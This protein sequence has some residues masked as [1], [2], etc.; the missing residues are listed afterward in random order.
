MSNLWDFLKYGDWTF[1]RVYRYLL[2]PKGK[3]K[4]M[5]LFQKGSEVEGFHEW[6]IKRRKNNQYG[7]LKRLEL[8]LNKLSKLSL[9]IEYTGDKDGFNV[10]CESLKR[11]VNP[12]WELLISGNIEVEDSRCVNINPSKQID[13]SHLACIKCGDELEEDALYKIAKRIEEKE[14]DIIYT[15]EARVVDKQYV[16]HYFKPDWSPDTLLSKNYLGYFTFVKKELLDN[17]DL[18]NY[19]QNNYCTLLQ[20][21]DQATKIGHVSEVLIYKKNL[22]TVALDKLLEVY[23]KRV[24]NCTV[25][26]IEEGIYDVRYMLSRSKKVSIIIPTKDRSDVLSVC[27]DSIFTKSSYQDFE[28]IVLDNNS[29]EDT[30]FQLLKDWEIKE[31]K[32]FKSLRVEAPFNFSSLMNVGV[33]ASSGDFVL[34]LNND[35]EVISEDWLERMMEQA[36]RDSVGVVGAKLYFPNDTVQHAGIIIG[37][38]GI[39]SEHLLLGADRDEKGYHNNLKVTTNYSALTA[40]CFMVRREVYDEVGGFDELFEVEFNDVDFCLRVLEAGYNNVFVP[41]VELYH[42]ESISRGHPLRSKSSSIR[43]DRE[44]SLFKERWQRYIDNDPYFNPNFNK[45]SNSFDLDCGRV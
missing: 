40:A 7:E 23:R 2:S 44:L 24:E 22:D 45:L 29:T 8:G 9:F 38:G 32:R 6:V 36:Q 31:P 41:H 21:T 42:Y 4:L 1:Y 33:E 37:M 3:A 28:V 15:D 12:N 30:L 10:T 16:D 18:V 35:T 26:E 25:N 39:G 20:L 5:S 19:S 17:L 27:L 11:Q 14:E 43:H 34:L 13:G